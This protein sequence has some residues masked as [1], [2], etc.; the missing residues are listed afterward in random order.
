MAMI[1]IDFK[2]GLSKELEKLACEILVL[3]RKKLEIQTK[4]GNKNAR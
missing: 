1:V 2:L 3:L 4:G